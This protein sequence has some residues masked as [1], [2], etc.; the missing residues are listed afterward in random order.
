MNIVNSG[1]RFMVYGEAVKTYK[2]LPADTYQLNFNK[3]SG[4]YLT[5]HNDLTVSEKIYGPY[6]KKVNKVMK[7]FDMLDRN[8]GIILSGPKGVGKSVFARLLAEEGKKKNLP[9]IIVSEAVGGLENFLSSIDQE[10]IILFDEFEKTFKGEEDSVDPQNSLLSL[11]DG[12]DN[13]KK[14]YVITCNDTNRLSNYLLN[15]PGRFHYHFILNAPNREEVQEYLEDNLNEDAKKYMDELISISSISSFTYDILRAIVF[16]L[17]NGYGLADTLLDLNIERDTDVAFK[18][19]VKFTNGLIASTTNNRVLDLASSF[20]ISE[21][22]KFNK[23]EVPV[24][25]QRY[26]DECCIEFYPNA[27]KTNTKG[28]TISP[29]SVEVSFS[30]DW[31]FE[32]KEEIKQMAEEFINSCNIEEVILERVARSHYSNKRKFLF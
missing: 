31:N 32:D 26:C 21:W 29:E 1:D 22:L 15:R 6:I 24:E 18:I 28:Y 13:G 10:C 30:S 5:L 25:I 20:R 7:T 19:A 2:Q 11:F 4:F 23:K 27:V 3:M 9:L 16:E 14:L 8:M 12:I 17:N